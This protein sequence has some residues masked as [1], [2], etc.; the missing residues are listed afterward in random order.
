MKRYVSVEIYSAAG[1]RPLSYSATVWHTYSL[2][3]SA[4]ENAGWW[5]T[6][7][8]VVVVSVSDDTL[9]DDIVAEA[10]AAVLPLVS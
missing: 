8:Y 1:Y 4:A 5:C 9:H 2:A 7:V 3:S 10:M 6:A